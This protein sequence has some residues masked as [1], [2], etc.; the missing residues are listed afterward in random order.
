MLTAFFPFPSLF[1]LD[2][3][4]CATGLHQCQTLAYGGVCVNTSPGYRCECKEGTQG[5]GFFCGAINECKL[6]I[7]QCHTLPHRK[8]IDLPPYRGGYY[9]FCREGFKYH[10][11]HTMVNHFLHGEC[12]DEDECEDVNP[13]A[14]NN[15]MCVNTIG[16]YLCTPI[17]HPPF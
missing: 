1:L 10:G 13:C 16:S 17:Y 4:E 15:T 5:S 2:F 6:G 11:P 12:R 9:C 14:F 3:D 7:D 8:C